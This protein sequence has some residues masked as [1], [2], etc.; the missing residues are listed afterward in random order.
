MPKRVI[1][2]VAIPLIVGLSAYLITRAK[3]S[4]GPLDFRGPVFSGPDVI[5]LGPRAPGP[6]ETR[7]M[8]SNP[9]HASL[10]ISRIQ[11]G[12]GCT[13]IYADGTSDAQPLHRLSVP[14][15][16]TTTLVARVSLRREAGADFR[17]SIQFSTNDPARPE[18]SVPVTALIGGAVESQPAHWLVGSIVQRDPM[19]CRVELFDRGRF[20]PCQIDLV[21]SSHPALVRVVSF[22]PRDDALSADQGR[23]IG[24]VDLQ[25]TPPAEPGDVKA[26]VSVFEKD[27]TS[28]VLSIPV[29]G[30]K[31]PRIQALPSALILPLRTG[32][33]P[34]KSATVV[35]QSPIGQTFSLRVLEADGLT[36]TLP[37]GPP[38]AIVAVGVEW[39][40]QTPPP[41]QTARKTARLRATFGTGEFD[42]SIPVTYRS[43]DEPTG[44]RP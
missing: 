26:V 3:S 2:L 33:G 44:P 40:G 7:F 4:E 30:R 5:D 23:R 9:G 17:T 36:V 24:V 38:A 42:V 20:T 8:I 19:R 31:P 35:V 13:V 10:E 1:V 6:A 34:M 43:P 16:S 27:G 15:G 11:I 22:E 21:E 39:T 12:C 29:S 25:L 37:A 28:P 32:T 18:V 14:P 41:G